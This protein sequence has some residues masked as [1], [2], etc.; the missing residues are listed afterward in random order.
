MAESSFVSDHCF[1][2][3]KK[4]ILIRRL[5]KP[6]IAMPEIKHIWSL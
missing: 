1:K 6:N 2:G 4:F 5:I 3:E